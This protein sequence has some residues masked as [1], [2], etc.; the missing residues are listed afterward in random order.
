MQRVPE[1]LWAKLSAAVE[2]HGKALEKLDWETLANIPEGRRSNGPLEGLAFDAAVR[3][4]FLGRD[5][6]ALVRIGKSLEVKLANQNHMAANHENMAMFYMA[7]LST[8]GCLRG[9]ATSDAMMVLLM[10]T[11]AITEDGGRWTLEDPDTVIG[12][13]HSMQTLVSC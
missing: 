7:T 1:N 11:L 13:M 8:S 4:T 3:R 10:A 5:P 9:F 12:S 2:A 6:E